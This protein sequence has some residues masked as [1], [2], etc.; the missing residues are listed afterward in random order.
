MELSVTLS[1]FCHKTVIKSLESIVNAG[2]VFCISYFMLNQGKGSLK[3]H[4]CNMKVVGLSK[5]KK[6]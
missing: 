1:R 3:R 4:F 6:F 2:F 5:G